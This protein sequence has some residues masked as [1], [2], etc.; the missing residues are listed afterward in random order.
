MEIH[1][2]P[3]GEPMKFY[4]LALTCFFVSLS[5]PC[6]MAGDDAAEIRKHAEGARLALS[7]ND[8]QRAE[9]EY[10]AI[11]RLDPHNAS[12]H[13]A[14]GVTLYGLGKAA[15]AES[16]LKTALQ[17]DASQSQAE[18]FLGLSEAELG[19]CKEATP[20]L[21]KPFSAQ[22]DSKLRRLVGLSLLNCQVASSDF[23]SAL[24]VAHTLR[25][26]Y[27]DDPDVLY[28]LAE[29]YTRLWNSVASD[30]MEKHPESYRVHQLGGEVME[31][32][33]RTDRAIKEYQL[34]LQQNPKVP[35]LNYRIGRLLLE[36]GGPDANHAAL[37][38][39]QQ[40][41]AIN[42]GDAPSEYSIGV[43]YTN[44]HQLKQADEHF[45]NAKKID[46]QFAD[47]YVGLA[48][49]F[50][51]QKQ[52]GKAT[53]ELEKAIQ[54][55]PENASAHYELMEA[56]RDQGRLADAQREM[57]VFQKLQKANAEKFRARL[58]SLLSGQTKN[59]KNPD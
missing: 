28:N 57:A 43:I 30:L 7:R 14:L 1:V 36:A 59:V 21:V 27:P 44:L 4:R 53:N 54:L 22:G 19:Q 35:Q 11:L 16:A 58:D 10:Q 45:V 37:E 48:K 3:E 52:P 41:L 18:T 39:F 12:V 46:P 56:Y 32:Q 15:E 55:S 33:G 8:L 40:E 5:V 24:S 50:L 17:L 47:A 26:S 20:L 51:Q 31:A 6:M 2:G 9:E 34:A 25:R 49:V 42:P 23:D 13:T 29:L 38:K